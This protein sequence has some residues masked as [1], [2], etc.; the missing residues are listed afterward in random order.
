MLSLII[1][2]IAV[3]LATLTGWALW[4]SLSSCT[5][6][7]CGDFIK[8]QSKYQAAFLIVALLVS[9][10]SYVVSVPGADQVFGIGAL[11]SEVQVNAFGFSHAAMSSWWQFGILCTLGFGLTTYMLCSSALRR[12]NNWPVFLRRLQP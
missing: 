5:T 3:L 4:K 9:I 10:L 8:K 1:I 6:V 2:I 11:G 7:L 12:I